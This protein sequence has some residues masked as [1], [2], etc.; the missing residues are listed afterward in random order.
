MLLAVAAAGCGCCVG[1]L[2]SPLFWLHSDPT[3]FP[4]RQQQSGMY[5]PITPF[6]P[7]S[8]RILVLALCSTTMCV[9]LVP[10]LLIQQEQ[11]LLAHSPG[12]G[13]T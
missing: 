3:A 11:A 9:G 12:T 1:P 13:H 2:P 7:D 8:L 6:P 10:A 4:W 5:V